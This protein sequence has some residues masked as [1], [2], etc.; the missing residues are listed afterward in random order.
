MEIKINQL[1]DG[2]F[3]VKKFLGGGASGK[4]YRARL[5]KDWGKYKKG[6]RFA[7]KVYSDEIFNR[8]KEDVIYARRVR[9]AAIGNRVS[10][11]NVLKTYDT[12]E[13]WIDGDKPQ[14]LLMEYIK[15]DQLDEW[16]KGNF[17]L[18]V[19]T[20]YDISLQVAEGLKLLH[21]KQII[22]RDVKAANVIITK[23]GRVVLLDLGVVRPL[24]E[25]TITG[26]ESFLGTLRYG[27]P[28]WLIEGKYSRSSDVYSLGTVI[29]LLLH[30][31]D[32][33]PDISLFS[34]LVIA[35]ER[36]IP[37]S[38][39]KHTG[40]QQA[41]LS[42]LA[43]NMLSKNLKDRPL[44][45]D[46]IKFLRSFDSSEISAQLRKKRLLSLLPNLI[47]D[48]DRE[49]TL[50][51]LISK[52]DREELDSALVNLDQRRIFNL[53]DINKQ[54]AEISLLETEE[55]GYLALPEI[56][57]IEWVKRSFA[58]LDALHGWDDGANIERKWHLASRIRGLEKSPEILSKMRELL[59]EAEEAMTEMIQVFAQ[60][61]PSD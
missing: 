28:E 20:I 6:D 9:E 36:D 19:E 31:H 42:Q 46:V 3:R 17:P 34:R 21:A 58:V 59:D 35:V 53:L 25:G 38:K 39:T 11:V 45:D 52:A 22:H 50:N 32:I 29:Y 40:A 14:Y 1:V 61:N 33:F 60:E 2:L 48:S 13:F 26:S 15:G 7:L 24:E 30:G 5:E 51:L 56:E 43:D 8:E 16:V 44:L 12:S 47:S 37:K 55:N 57:R 23:E 18:S 10:S 54:L 41:Y 49:A 27:A 4:V